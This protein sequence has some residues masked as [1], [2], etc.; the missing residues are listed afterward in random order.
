VDRNVAIGLRI[1]EARQLKGWSQEQLSQ[2]LNRNQRSVSHLENGKVNI[3]LSDLYI[4]AEALEQPI[5]FFLDVELDMDVLED[6][7][8]AEFKQ[9]PSTQA[10][11]TALEMLRTFRRFVSPDS[12]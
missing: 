1:K 9:L 6:M 4:V 5:S 12:K 10:K 11:Q 8:I 3:L 2:S 7:I